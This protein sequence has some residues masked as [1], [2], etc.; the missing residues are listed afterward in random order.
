[1]K[2]KISSLKKSEDFKIPDILCKPLR[3]KDYKGDHLTIGFNNI[4]EELFSELDKK[5]ADEKDK[6][7]KNRIHIQNTCDIMWTTIGLVFAAR[8]LAIIINP[9][10]QNSNSYEG[11][12][13]YPIQDGCNE[14]K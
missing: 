13:V 3:V 2:I 5:E 6:E 4:D 9:S 12:Q 10:A 1:M 7:K 11:N 8:W 14:F